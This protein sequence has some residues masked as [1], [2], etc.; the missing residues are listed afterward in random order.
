VAES[1]YNWS[2]AA[3]A[4]YSTGTDVDGIAVADAGTLTTDEISQDTKGSTAVCVISV[5]DDT[6]VCDG[7][8]AVYILA[9]DMD[10]DSEGW[11]AITDASAQAFAIDQVQ[12]T[13]ERLPFT[14]HGVD[15]PKFKL[16]IVNDAGQEVAITINI[17]QTTIPAA[18]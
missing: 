12:N 11:Q 5:E 15:M 8:V 4:T 18:S 10:P 3:H 7:N 14:I 9:P 17:E 2:A 13:T 16:H 1:G 6:G